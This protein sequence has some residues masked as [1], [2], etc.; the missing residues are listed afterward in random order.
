MTRVIIAAGLVAE[1]RGPLLAPLPS[2]MLRD[3]Q[4]MVFL[5]SAV[6]DW[7][8]SGDT[9]RSASCAMKVSRS[10]MPLAGMPSDASRSPW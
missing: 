8:F 5:R 3:S 10:F 2:P 9:T 4:S 1:R 6:I 7:L